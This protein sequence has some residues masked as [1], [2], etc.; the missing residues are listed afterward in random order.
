MSAIKDCRH[1]SDTVSH[2]NA[3]RA[4]NDRIAHR[5]EAL[6]FASR[7]PML[8]ECGRPSCRALVLLALEDFRHLRRSGGAVIADEHGRLG[9]SA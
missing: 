2:L 8:C 4:S 9:R 5:A 7:V 6:R 3:V 1:D